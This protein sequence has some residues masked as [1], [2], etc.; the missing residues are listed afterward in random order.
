MTPFPPVIEEAARALVTACRARSITL[1]TA[2]SCTG[3]LI[4]AAITEIAGSSDVFDR[5][6]ITY[7]NAAK[8]DLLDVPMALIEQYGA[9]SEPVARAM[10]EGALHHSRADIAVSVT[11]I[12]GPGGGSAVKPVGLVWFGLACRGATTKCIQREFGD[13]GR[14]AVRMETVAQALALLMPDDRG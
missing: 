2:E 14:A 3:G 13:I 4:G 12:A 8:Q 5:G 6:F 1:A 9:V 7:S 11:G 10:A